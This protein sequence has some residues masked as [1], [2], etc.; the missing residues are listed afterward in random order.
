MAKKK[1][2]TPK[3]EIPVNEGGIAVGVPK[4]DIKVDA[5]STEKEDL[6]KEDKIEIGEPSP[7]DGGIEAMGEAP[8][9][10]DTDKGWVSDPASLRK[11][12]GYRDTL[13]GTL[14]FGIRK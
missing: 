11:V 7:Y 6:P 10:D 9:E 1:K 5:I 8:I 14:Y 3:E 4:E 2:T 13:N 12:C